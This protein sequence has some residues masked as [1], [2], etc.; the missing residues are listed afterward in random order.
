[1]MPPI[2][3][4]CAVPDCEK[5]A[6]EPHI[7]CNYHVFV[8]ITIMVVTGFALVSGAILFAYWVNG[9]Q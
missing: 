4:K 6:A 9:G 2:S 3:F 5:D 8:E 7:I 1:M